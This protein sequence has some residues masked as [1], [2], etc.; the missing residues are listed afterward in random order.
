MLSAAPDRCN[1]DA[2]RF[3]QR[4]IFLAI[5]ADSVWEGLNDELQLGCESYDQDAELLQRLPP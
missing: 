1:G 3:R 2:G 5:P 4:G